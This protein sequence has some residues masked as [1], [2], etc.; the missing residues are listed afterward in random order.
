MA[1]KL[2]V[3]IPDFA[4]IHAKPASVQS[5]VT[6]RS[7]LYPHACVPKNMFLGGIFFSLAPSSLLPPLTAPRCL[8]SYRCSPYSVATATSGGN[9]YTVTSAMGFLRTLPLAARAWR[10]YGVLDSVVSPT[11]TFAPTPPPNHTHGN[12]VICAGFCSPTCVRRKHSSVFNPSLLSLAN[13]F[14]VVYQSARSANR[15]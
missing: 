9:P 10:R 8:G 15:A 5:A 14:H 7:L 12:V 4:F 11:L 2:I 1:G 3:G 6:T 13:S